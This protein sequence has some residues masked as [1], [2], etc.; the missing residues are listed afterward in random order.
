M[1][2]FEESNFYKALQDFFINADKKTFLQ[3]LAEFYN[4]TEGIIDKDNIQ[5]DLIKEL[6]ELYLEFNEKGIDENI[7]RE[8]VNHF[9]E[10]NVKIKDIIAKLTTNTNNI[11]NITSQ[12]VTIENNVD[13][14]M[15]KGESISVLQIDKNRGKLDQTYMTDE[16]L[17]Q[18]AG[19]TP[20][21]S[22]PADNS[23]TESKLD[24]S[25]SKSINKQHIKVF[26]GITNI[27][28][29]NYNFNV[30][31]TPVITIYDKKGQ[32]WTFN[33]VSD[34]VL[35]EQQILIADVENNAAGGTYDLTTLTNPATNVINKI[36]ICGNFYGKF[37]SDVTL[38]LQEKLKLI[39]EN[40]SN[41][42]SQLQLF[43]IKSSMVA[44]PYNGRCKISFDMNSKL[45]KIEGKI[46][47]RKIKGVNASFIIP[48]YETNLSNDTIVYISIDYIKNASSNEIP[49]EE[50][51]KGTIYS[52]FNPTKH[53]PLFWYAHGHIGTS[54]GIEI[55]KIDAY[56]KYLD[57]IRSSMV[58]FPYNKNIK[59]TFD[60][61][62][63]ILSTNGSIYIRKTTETVKSIIIPQFEFT[64]SD[65]DV[66]YIDPLDIKS[67]VSELPL[68]K[69]YKG[70]VYENFDINKHIP[71][72]WYSYG[73]IMTS[74]R[75]NID[76]INSNSLSS[77]L[78]VALFG[79]SLTELAKYPEKLQEYTG[80]NVY[81]CS[82][83]GSVMA[84][85]SDE[86]YQNL[87]FMEI[88]K[89][90][91][92]G[93]F[94]KQRTAINN[95]VNGSNKEP[96]FQTLSTLNFNKVDI[97][98]VL[99]G[100]N[101]WGNGQKIGSINDTKDTKSLVGG[102]KTGIENILSKYPNIQLYFITPPY[103][104]G[105]LTLRDGKNLKEW[106]DVI[107]ETAGL[108]GFP[109]LNGITN[110]GIN[111]QNRDYYL[112]EDKLHLNNKGDGLVA[113][114]VGNFITSR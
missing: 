102:L 32:K 43:G 112:N 113:R 101:D 39:A 23:I 16:F 75:L 103:R 65:F 70:L 15:G 28:Q 80:Y 34:F 98:V 53:I 71:L 21:N 57:S 18:M 1:S 73:Q 59:I 96:N 82:F 25:F 99:Y 111:E 2:K 38:N 91:V 107:C 114:K 94:T 78:N 85:H 52:D 89:S 69:I 9:V 63:N 54:T 49:L 26:G 4:R 106:G 93:D 84:Y 83:A 40:K 41:I 90:I 79:D 14:K 76:I 10:N 88:S 55:E 17:Q 7:V 27:I 5:D 31:T 6:R 36:V 109:S 87:G 95:I 47:I 12:L 45:L 46:Y 61:N 74:T 100:T 30:T 77:K 105:W 42:D 56:K 48:S 66:I 60:K 51:K 72:F 20:I 3:F 86:N 19:N 110:L 24:S 62:G 35:T 58:A 67:D 13:L 104:E 44:I 68:E 92:S 108:Y 81:D 37:F 97:I 64:M 33:G 29:D 11:K 8:K 22:V 50:I